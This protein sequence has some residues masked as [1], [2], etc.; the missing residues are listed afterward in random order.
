VGQ[1][2]SAPLTVVGPNFAIESIP[3]VSPLGLALMLLAL[4]GVGAFYLRRR[5]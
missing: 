4:S 2:A 1:A 5:G 3:T